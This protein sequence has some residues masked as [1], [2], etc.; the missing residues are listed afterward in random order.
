M[1]NWQKTTERSRRRRM[2]VRRTLRGTG[3]RPRLTVFRSNRFIYAQVIDDET[4]RTLACS[5]SQT[6]LKAG[7]LKAKYPGNREAAKEV[8]ADIAEK[9]KENGIARVR[10]DRGPYKYHGRVMAL[11][12]G[13]REGGL[14]F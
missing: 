5:S 3:E 13:A 1:K 7:V 2:R 10:F 4:G 6:L 12:E 9:A 8:G 14:D 11:A